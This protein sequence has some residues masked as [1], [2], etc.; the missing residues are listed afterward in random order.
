MKLLSTA[1]VATLM[2]GLWLSA[3][4]AEPKEPAARDI[5]AELRNTVTNGLTDEKVAAIEKLGSITDTQRLSDFGV[6]TFLV[7]VIKNG[8]YVPRVRIAAVKAFTNVVK[9]A[10]DAKDA[11]L[12]V[13]AACLKDQDKARPETDAMRRTVAE[14][15]GTMLTSGTPGDRAAI[16]DLVQIAGDRRNPTPVVCASLQAL[17]AIGHREAANVMIQAIKDGDP[18]IQESGLKAIDL[19]FHSP[20]AKSVSLDMIRMLQGLVADKGLSIEARKAAMH[21]LIGAVGSSA[22]NFKASDVC[23]PLAAMLAETADPKL[24]EAIVNMLTRVPEQEAVDALVKA[25][26][27]FGKPAPAGQDFV[28]VR[29]A[30]AKAL[31][32]FFHPAAIRR[33]TKVGEAACAQLIKMLKGDKDPRVTAAAVYALGNMVD[34][35][36]DRKAVVQ[37]LIETLSVD[38]DR[39]VTSSVRET[40]TLITG[41]EVAAGEVDPKEAAKE[42]KKWYAANKDSLTAR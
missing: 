33:D 30:V 26:D 41:R 15:L 23:A 25:C 31:G 13:L 28:P 4:A 37:E 40:L 6:P 29:V 16:N 14:A 21:A 35:V 8:E 27:A 39:K 18:V 10:P 2:T 3:S 11:A 17:G 24:A 9:F 38:A 19:L 20:N 12:P 42:W 5:I 34:V 22:G 32:E 1:L 36:Y 7:S